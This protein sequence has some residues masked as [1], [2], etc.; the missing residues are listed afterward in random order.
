MELQKQDET[1]IAKLSSKYASL[2]K[3]FSVIDTALCKYCSTR[4]SP[5]SEPEL[6]LD[7]VLVAF[8]GGKDCTLMLHL[9]LLRVR[10]LPRVQGSLRLMYIQEPDGEEFPEVHAFVEQTKALLDL[11]SIEVGSG[12]LRK[13]LE[14][15]VSLH[16]EVQ[17]IFMGTRSTDPNAGWMDYFC[18]TSP[19][20]PQVDLVAPILR[21]TYSELWSIIH[22]LSVDVCEMYERGYT[23]IGHVSN[24]LPNPA[25]LTEDGSYLHADQLNDESL[26]RLGRVKS[27]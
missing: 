2:D 25:L 24:T 6:D 5:S 16:P 27:K 17:A 11:E 15:I 26:E 8:N 13:G 20:W 7:K 21:M 23:S 9:I 19:G 4:S 10:E 18:R 22:G 3:A 14:S 12:D 1:Q